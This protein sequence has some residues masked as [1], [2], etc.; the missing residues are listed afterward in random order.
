MSAQPPT[1]THGLTTVDIDGSAVHLV[2]G[3][4]AQATIADAAAHVSTRPLGVAS[5][6]LDHV[7]HFGRSRRAARGDT[8]FVESG[9]VEWLNLIDGKPIASQIAR[10]TG[11]IY[12]K[13]SGSDLIAGVLDGAAARGRSIGVL[14]GMPDVRAALHSRLD[15]EWPTT[16]FAGH[17]TPDRAVLTSPS[18]SAAL[19][20]DIRA[21][22]V[23]I[24]V[25]CLGKPRQEIWIDQHG[26][27]TG[28]GALLA[29]GAVVDFLAGRVARAPEWA[30]H[31]GVEWAWRL[32]HEPRRLARRY[33][34]QGPPAYAAMRRSTA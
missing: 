23:D 1:L 34:V 11:R 14:G 31:A 13:L 10:M 25:V 22:G 12:P 24:L 8:P 5:I 21:A 6:N 18:E 26:P 2:D 20:C 9:E 7:H 17:W 33:L 30:S 4:T 27:Q 15:A 32:M 3:A 19:A 28:A 16:R 29:F